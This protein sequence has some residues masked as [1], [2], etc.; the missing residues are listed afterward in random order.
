MTAH[1]KLEIIQSLDFLSGH[2]LSSGHGLKAEPV[3]N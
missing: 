2:G 1:K 3:K